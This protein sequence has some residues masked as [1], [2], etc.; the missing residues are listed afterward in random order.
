M[1]CYQFDIQLD[2]DKR[3]KNTFKARKEFS[4]SKT[5]GPVP[6]PVSFNFF[7]SVCCVRCQFFFFWCRTLGGSD[8]NWLLFFPDVLR[9]HD[10]PPGWN[11]ARNNW[12]KTKMLYAVSVI[13]IK[14]PWTRTLSS[15]S[16]LIYH[17]S[18][19]RTAV[20]AG[21]LF[22]EDAVDDDQ[23]SFHL[24]ADGKSK[25]HPNFE[26]ALTASE[27]ICLQRINGWLRPELFLNGHSVEK[28]FRLFAVRIFFNFENCNFTPHS[29]SVSWTKLCGQVIPDDATEH[30]K[31]AA[32]P[33]GWISRWARCVPAA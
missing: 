2:K 12:Q 20:F 6:E 10:D 33:G 23:R 3:I 29:S 24:A 17:S 25:R 8:K 11:G 21:V 15:S 4:K 9:R 18:S 16:R 19:I 14:K 26:W 27:S 5:T 32:P 13:L 1:S 7:F 22:R 30:P 28:Q 31:I